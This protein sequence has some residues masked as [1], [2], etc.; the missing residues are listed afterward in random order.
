[1]A[2]SPLRIF[3]IECF[4]EIV[5][6]AEVFVPA[7]ATLMQALECSVAAGFKPLCERLNAHSLDELI[8]GEIG[9][10]GKRAKLN[11]LVRADDRI[12]FYRPLLVDTKQARQLRVLAERRRQAQIRSQPKTKKEPQ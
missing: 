12:E 10:N 3:A 6:R 8:A 2:A 9:L 4:D 1:M 11:Q 7:G 5:E